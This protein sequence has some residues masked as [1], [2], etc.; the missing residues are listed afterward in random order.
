MMQKFRTNACRV[1]LATVRMLGIVS[2]TL[3]IGALIALIGVVLLLNLAGAGDYVIR[4]LTSKYLGTLPPGFAA[5]KRGF[6]VYAILVV[7][8]GTFFVGVAL[9]A[10]VLWL[11]L[12]LL[13]VSLAVFLAASVLAIRGE[14]ATARGNKP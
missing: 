13:G 14:V 1:V 3:V 12:A 7:S 2:A 10:A 5:S 9:A 4:H 8:I 6:S 11:G